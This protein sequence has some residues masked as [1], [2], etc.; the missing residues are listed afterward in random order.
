M[1]L[2]EYRPATNTMVTGLTVPEASEL[3][4]L[5]ADSNARLAELAKRGERWRPFRTVASWYLWRALE[6]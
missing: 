3:F 1:V 6:L 4:L 5:A 2:E